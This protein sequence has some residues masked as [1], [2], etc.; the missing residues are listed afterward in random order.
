MKSKPEAKVVAVA[1]GAAV[2]V[3]HQKLGRGV[4]SYHN[5][6]DTLPR[7]HGLLNK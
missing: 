3:E 2:Q 4:S 5:L 7:S 6:P 1:P